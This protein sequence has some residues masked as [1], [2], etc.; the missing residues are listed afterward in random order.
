[1]KDDKKSNRILHHVVFDSNF[2]RITFVQLEGSND[3]SK[4]ICASAKNK[5]S[6]FPNTIYTLHVTKKNVCKWIVVVKSSK[7]KFKMTSKYHGYSLKLHCCSGS[8]VQEG[9]FIFIQKVNGPDTFFS[10]RPVKNKME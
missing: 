9:L 6:V 10:R 8:S 3:G 2:R 1:M 7:M 4:F 5:K